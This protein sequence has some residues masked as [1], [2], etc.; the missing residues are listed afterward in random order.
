MTA[1]D[2]ERRL[3]A[4]LHQHA[5]EAMG[6]T[7]TVT[8]LNKYQARVEQDNRARS[9]RRAG[10]AAAALTAAAVGVGAIWFALGQDE[11][12]APV[13]PAPPA[14]SSSPSPT[15]SE[16]PE[17]PE[18][19][20]TPGS[21]VEGF[22][23]V[24]SFPMTF[25]VPRG[26]SDPFRDSGTRGYSI[27]GTSG[28]A[29]AFLV[30]TFNQV[31]ASELPDD[32]AAYVRETR[33]DLIVSNIS[34]TEVGGRPAQTFSLAQKPG[35]PPYELFCVRNGGCFKLLED[36]PMDVTAVRTGNG[37]V[38][39]WVEY[40]PKDQAKVQEPMQNWLASVRWE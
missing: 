35:R 5:E 39:F 34:T 15:A 38:L 24:E 30:S 11:S 7:D 3:A 14:A 21:I 8:E 25:V 9:R 20:Q 19:P 27:D 29:A 26:F 2:V 12:P 28:S 31:A 22:E 40:L 6:R 23:Q 33:D 37:L 17:E 1:S 18:A 4:I 10:T 16:A 32:L 36:K 13:D